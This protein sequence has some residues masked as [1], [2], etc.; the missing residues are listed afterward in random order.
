MSEKFETLP[1]SVN[2]KNIGDEP[3]PTSDE[4]KAAIEMIK[5][6]LKVFILLFNYWDRNDIEDFLKSGEPLANTVKLATL[7]LVASIIFTNATIKLL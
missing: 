4:I 6:N 2:S 5:K 3:F 1:P 7:F